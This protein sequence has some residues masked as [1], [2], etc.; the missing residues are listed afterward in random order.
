MYQNNKKS[1]VRGTTRTKVSATDHIRG[2][3]SLD[4]AFR[5]APVEFKLYAEKLW[6]Q[7]KTE[8]WGQ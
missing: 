3:Y 2:E 6:K 8:R 1:T 4:A 5:N 7:H